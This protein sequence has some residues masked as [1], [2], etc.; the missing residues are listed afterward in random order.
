MKHKTKE[1]ERIRANE[2]QQLLDTPMFK[3]AVTALR[4]DLFQKFQDTKWYES[5]SRTEVWRKMQ[6]VDAI[7]K[8]LQ[9][10]V[11][12]GKMGRL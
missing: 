6:T 3:E 9:R 4:A 7:E 11:T 8:Y 12:T 10:I 2:A 1:Q 5:K